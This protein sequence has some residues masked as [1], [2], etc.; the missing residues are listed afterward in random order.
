MD[1]L[2]EA[3]KH[4]SERV[5]A[6]EALSRG[7]DDWAPRIVEGLWSIASS[8]RLDD[9]VVD[10]LCQLLDCLLKCRLD[11]PSREMVVTW[12]L[13]CS[14]ARIIE[15]TDDT[16]EFAAALKRIRAAVDSLTSSSSSR[17]RARRDAIIHCINVSIRPALDSS[18][19]RWAKAPVKA[20]ITA[21]LQKRHLFDDTEYHQL[22]SCIAL[23]ESEE[24]STSLRRHH[25][26]PRVA[27]TAYHPL[28]NVRRR[29][30]F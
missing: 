18:K 23:I 12:S 4:E 25:L 21:T 15:R 11:S 17:A 26:A 19:S 5:R 29:R 28:R 30:H 14:T 27:E 13:S 24:R 3:L 16:Y 10:P 1:G 6:L 7:C 2:C 9:D 20:C 8:R 22:Q